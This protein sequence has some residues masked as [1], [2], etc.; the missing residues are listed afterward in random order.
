MADAVNYPP[1][2]SKIAKVLFFD[3]EEGIYAH[4]GP[5]KNR[6]GVLVETPRKMGV[7]F[8]SV[9][10]RVFEATGMD[11]ILSGPSLGRPVC[12]FG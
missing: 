6:T 10:G 9:P 12:H 2:K 1:A 11:L 4:S 3:S 5:A 7:G 8:R